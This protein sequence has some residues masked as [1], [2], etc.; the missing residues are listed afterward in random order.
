MK[1]QLDRVADEVLL[2]LMKRR[3]MRWGRWVESVGPLFPCYL[4]ALVDLERQWSDIRRIC[5]V[6]EPVRFGP[7]PAEVPGWIISELKERCASG[8]LELWDQR[9]R[10][11]A[12][13]KVMS[14]PFREFEGIFEGYRSGSERVAILLSVMGGTRALVNADQI[15]PLA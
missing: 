13:I 14:G 11:G 9:L 15:A 7:E 8:P 1:G 4:F 12:R 6:R 3:V 10:P 5:G 2:P